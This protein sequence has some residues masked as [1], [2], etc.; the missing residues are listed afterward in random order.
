M[1]DRKFY[2][3]QLCMT[4]L[5]KEGVG[6]PLSWCTTNQ[7]LVVFTYFIPRI[8][9]HMQ[10]YLTTIITLKINKTDVHAIED[11]GFVH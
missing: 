10:D 6:Y 5:V 9:R 4:W 3:S 1:D 11:L 7:R 8:K 2:Y